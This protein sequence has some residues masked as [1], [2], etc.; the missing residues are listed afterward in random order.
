VTGGTEGGKFFERLFFFV[1][2]HIILTPKCHIFIQFHKFRVRKGRIRVIFEE[3]RQCA[4]TRNN[5]TRWR[6]QYYNGQVIRVSNSEF[7]FVALGTQHGM[8][9]RR[10]ILSSVACPL[11]THFPKLSHKCHDFRKTN[12][13]TIKYVFLLSIQLLSET[14]LILRRIRQY[15]IINVRKSY[16]EV[17][18]ILA[19]S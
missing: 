2:K 3:G 6:N 13:L 5:E 4:N 14:F 11:L 12:L 10:I 7:V 1:T 9:M 19:R 16:C 18:T 8:C 17:P 15:I